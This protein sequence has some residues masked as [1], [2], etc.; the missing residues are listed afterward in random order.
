M[1]QAK[2]NEVNS[3]GQDLQKNITKNKRREYKD[4]KATLKHAEI[5][6]VAKEM[7]LEDLADLPD[8]REKRITLHENFESK[9]KIS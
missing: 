7:T 2:A 6:L 9:S 8:I 5:E 3:E 4:L 1:E